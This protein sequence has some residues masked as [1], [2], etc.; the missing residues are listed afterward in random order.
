MAKRKLG[1]L[2][3]W[4]VSLIKGMMHHEVFETDQEI[5][6]HF[7]YPGRTVNNGRLSEIRKALTSKQDTGIPAIDRFRPQPVASREE[8][9]AFLAAP[10]RIDPRTGLDLQK[11][12]LVIKAREA[13]L[14]AVQG[15][16]S[17]TIRFKTETFIVL[18]VIAWTYLLLAF[19]TRK[20]IDCIYR[21]KNGAPKLTPNGRPKYLELE[22]LLKKQECPI[23]DPSVKANLLYLIG[24]RHE[25]EHRGTHQIDH[26]VASKVHACALNFNTAIKALFG[27]KCGLDHELGFAIQFASLDPVQ[28]RLMRGRQG[29]PKV[30]ET[31]N[32]AF[33][34]N[35]TQEI[36]NDPSYAYRVAIVPHAVNRPGQADEVFEI[37][38]PNSAEGRDIALILKDREKPKFLPKHVVRQMREAGYKNFN[39]HHHTRLWKDVGAKD[40]KK[41]YGVEVAGTWYW[42]QTWI[43]FVRRYCEEHAGRYR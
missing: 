4:E 39:M 25:I 35:L 27:P 12:E 19:Y 5:L 11:D 33:E 17:A 13:M 9:D 18:S 14:L 23:T 21:E 34:A 6:A 20:G 32:Q 2:E 28:R 29:L 15:Y 36:R 8:I 24:L 38:D 22:A 37:V 1:G 42:Y 41:G 31:Y 16:N 43:D 30:I 10:P 26:A 40:P 7:S 3:G